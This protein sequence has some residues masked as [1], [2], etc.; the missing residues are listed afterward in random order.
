MDGIPAPPTMSKETRHH[1][2]AIMDGSKETRYWVVGY[3]GWLMSEWN[4]LDYY[5]HLRRLY[6]ASRLMYP[7][8]HRL[9]AEYVKSWS[10]LLYEDLIHG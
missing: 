9:I 3:E 2:G 10:H 1:I 5:E 8:G 4:V 6:I 7:D